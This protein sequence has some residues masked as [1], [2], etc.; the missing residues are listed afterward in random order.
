M[1]PVTSTDGRAAR[2]RHVLHAR[3]PASRPAPAVVPLP[4]AGGTTFVE[5]VEAKVAGGI[6]VVSTAGLAGLA[7]VGITILVVLSVLELLPGFTF[8]AVSPP[9]SPSWDPPGETVVARSLEGPAPG[10]TGDRAARGAG[11][12]GPSAHAPVVAPVLPASGAATPVPRG[13]DGPPEES[14]EQAR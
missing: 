9:G 13:G 12:V 1:S 2:D 6:L 7:A 5:G 8:S 3:V 11:D 4:T 10:A 14:L